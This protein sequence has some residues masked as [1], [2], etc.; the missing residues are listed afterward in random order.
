MFNFDKS[1]L[2]FIAM[3]FL[4]ISPVSQSFEV[5][6]LYTGGIEK[7][8]AVLTP[9][10]FKIIKDV[11]LLTFTI[12][13][14]RK[15]LIKGTSFFKITT[16]AITMIFIFVSIIFSIYNDESIMLT[17]LGLHWFIP[18]FLLY[19]S[20][21]NI[22]DN[23]WKF[24]NKALVILFLAHF[25]L[26]VTQLF[27]S[28]GYYGALMGMSTRN[29]GIY[30][31]PNTASIFSIVCCLIFLKEKMTRMMLLSIL[32][33]VLT[34]SGTG[35]VVLMVVFAHRLFY[36]YR[37]YLYLISPFLLV[38]SYFILAYLLKFRGGEEYIQISLGT[39]LG[40]IYNAL[41]Y[42]P[43][44]FGEGTN[45]AL[46]FGLTDKLMDSTYAS[47]LVNTGY[48]G[49]LVYLFSLIVSLIIFEVN[50]NKDEASIIIVVLLISFTNIIMSISIINIIL[51]LAL[52]YYLSDRRSIQSKV[53]S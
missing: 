11:A 30:I 8:D 22:D 45:I 51:P 23:E 20:W 17:I 9:V 28:T 3:C 2:F 39:R 52:S 43:T 46:S 44:N 32:S 33:T 35:V 34:G 40:F 36:K 27:F 7:H 38:C 19:F 15:V 48:V 21:N 26:Q 13:F 49:F 53:I 29:P 24:L 10:Y 1:R 50:G 18:I 41:F 5:L 14:F 31:I 4:I 37:S 12:Y 16:I 47:I 42:W 25:S 6:K